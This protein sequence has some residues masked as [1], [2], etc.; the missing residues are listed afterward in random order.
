MEHAH[1]VRKVGQTLPPAQLKREDSL[2]PR[3]RERAGRFAL[4]LAR[5]SLPRDRAPR[6][7]T[8]L[9]G[10]TSRPGGLLLRH[11]GTGL[12]RGQARRERHRCKQECMSIPSS[13][14]LPGLLLMRS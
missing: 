12:P 5:G 11:T 3:Q 6:V 7:W 14:D 2:C 4:E 1:L 13:A 10:G 9:R 8:T